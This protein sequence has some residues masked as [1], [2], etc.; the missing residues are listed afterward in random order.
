[1]K[2]INAITLLFPF[3]LFN[4]SPATT[5]K[6]AV[7]RALA[8]NPEVLSIQKNT[9]AYRYYIDEEKAGFY[10]TIDLDIFLENKKEIK[11]PEGGSQTQVNKSGYNSQIQLEQ[12]LFDG[13]LT[14]ARVDE[15]SANFQKTKISNIFTIE[16]IIHE[17]VQ[18]YLDL[19]KF[20]ELLILSENNLVIHES[21]LDVA[22]ESE[23]VS[24]ETLDRIQVESKL[25]LA[26]SK[27]FQQKNDNDLSIHSFNKLVGFEP[28]DKICRP[29]IDTSLVPADV[30]EAKLDSIRNSYVILEEMENIK[31]QR[32]IISQEK[33]RFLPSLK[34]QLTEEYDND[35]DT[36]D[37]KS[38]STSAKLLLNY[39]LFNGFK[40]VSSSQ[41]ERIFLQESQKTLDDTVNVIEEDIKSSYSDYLNSTNKITYLKLYVEKNKEIL[42]VYKEQFSGGTRTFIDI[43]NSEAELFNAK[44]QLIEEEYSL[45]KSYYEILLILSRLS[46]TIVLSQNQICEDIV[47][48]LEPKQI[49]KVEKEV[50]NEDLSEIEDL[51][52]EDGQEGV[53][54]E[55]DLAGNDFVDEEAEKEKL[56]QDL[57]SDILDDIYKIKKSNLEIKDVI[58]DSTADSNVHDTMIED[59]VDSAVNEE[60]QYSE[61]LEKEIDENHTPA[62]ENKDE[63]SNDVESL[64]KEK[65]K[66]SETE[67]LE[68]II[69]IKS[70]KDRLLN[71]EESQF[72]LNLTTFSSIKNANEFVAS[73]ETLDD[74]FIYKFGDNLNYVKLINGIY[75]TYDEA[76]VAL[77][78]ISKDLDSD[79]FIID[80]IKKH[81]DLFLK[82]N[83]NYELLKKEK[84]RQSIKAKTT[85]KNIDTQIEELELII[86]NQDAKSRFLN[87]KKT[88]YVINMTTFNSVEALYS[89]VEEH[90]L[91]DKVF[92]FRFEE[93]K[94]LI[95]LVYGVY[96]SKEEAKLDLVKINKIEDINPI[97]QNAHDVQ[98]LYGLDNLDSN[99]E[100]DEVNELE[101]EQIMEEHKLEVNNEPASMVTI[102]SKVESIVIKPMIEPA[103]EEMVIIEEDSH[104]E[105]LKVNDKIVNQIEEV[106]LEDKSETLIVREINN[107]S[108]ELENNTSEDLVIEDMIKDELLSKEENISIE[109][110]DDVLLEEIETVEIDAENPMD[111]L[112]LDD[113]SSVPNIEEA[114]F[115]EVLVAEVLKLEGIE[116]PTVDT[117]IQAENE[118]NKVEKF[119][120][121]ENLHDD[122]LLNNN[123]LSGEAKV[124]NTVEKIDNEIKVNESTSLSSEKPEETSKTI[125]DSIKIISTN[126]MGENK[127]AKEFL[128]ETSNKYTI[129]ILNFENMQ[130]A[131]LYTNRYGLEQNSLVFAYEEK[132]KLIH[133]VYDSFQEAV[134]AS[135]VLHPFV[136]STH[137]YVRKIKGYQKLY[138]KFN[139]TQVSEKVDINLKEVS[140]LDKGTKILENTTKVSLIEEPNNELEAQT[141]QVKNTVLKDKFLNENKERYTISLA[142]LNNFKDSNLFRVKHHIQ[143]ELLTYK[144]K[145]SVRLIYGIYDSALETRMALEKLGSALKR[146][147]PFV[148]KLDVHQKLYKKYNKRIGE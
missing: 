144:F 59:K 68:E 104:D 101:V 127:L 23:D 135:K 1:M 71:S 37:S 120:D 55:A 32:A 7:E 125:E 36:K 114:S 10:P 14:S 91:F 78:K 117:V 145:N 118:D 40:D 140:V 56:V 98:K 48:D 19:V 111:N 39:N 62:N 12:M 63:V 136:L 28:S 146:N 106:L 17:A 82:Y 142:T 16:N 131:S 81:K 100:N 61:E 138:K 69:E 22:K 109:T 129:M 126:N 9:E 134:N 47:V 35:L 84:S 5:L 128:G 88:D 102:D 75:D 74:T 53:V 86:N 20:K 148:N 94:K 15:A 112:T 26:T 143:D 18:S 133:G 110:S 124:S 25:F 41:R 83:V 107:I 65:T 66:I 46:D 132:V 95:K 130:R 73:N 27:F 21:Y 50:V 11:N 87:A 147:K 51:L 90:A 34:F 42:S 45:L 49:K 92:A 97:I 77:N 30:D 3:L 105:V 60:I 76:L 4:S 29:Q 24:G 72:T 31:V 64:Q 57:V 123:I 121:K 93:N 6:E 67:V 70:F 89:F 116:S 79:L 33:S 103:T 13:G 38:H 96:G 2:H 119:S 139:N 44:T 58:D 80:T 43:L 137:P 99:E 8:N 141:L 108:E 122:D 115:D 52:A 113:E 85:K 54:T